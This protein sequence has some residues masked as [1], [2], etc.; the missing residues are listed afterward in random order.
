MKSTTGR[1]E[2]ISAVINYKPLVNAIDLEG[3]TSRSLYGTNVFND[4]VMRQHLSRPVYKALQRTIE[5]GDKLDVAVADAVATAM[6]TWALEKGAT[7]FTHVFYPLTSLTAEKHDSFFDPD[8]S[9]GTIAQFSGSALIQGEP[10]AS[11]FPSGGIRSTFEAR[12]YTA[13]DVTSPAYIYENPNGNTLCIPT[14]FLSWTGEALDHKT[15][16]LR[17]M[18]ALNLQAQ[19]ILKLFGHHDPGMVTATAGPEQEYFLIDR[20]FFFARPD[21][22][23]A[24]RTLFGAKPPKGQEFEDHYFGAIPERVLAFM[25]EAE[26]EFIQAGHSDQDAAQRGRTRSVRN[27]ARL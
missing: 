21:L 14:A 12:G 7:H 26:H 5:K 17:S 22:L 1:Q 16:L 25:M 23:N 20:N 10:D 13:W 19:R 8:G 9:G 4:A 2:A 3:E 24:G 6:K 15:P 27:R 18:Q 11:S